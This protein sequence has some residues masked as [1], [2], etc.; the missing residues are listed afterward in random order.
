MRGTTEYENDDADSMLGDSGFD[1]ARILLQENLVREKELDHIICIIHRDSFIID[2]SRIN[3]SIVEATQGSMTYSW[4]GNIVVARFEGVELD[5]EDHGDMTMDDFRHA[6]DY[7][8]C[9]IDRDSGIGY[10]INRTL[11]SRTD[12]VKGQSVQVVYN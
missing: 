3:R 12:P 6:V 11:G 1:E 4:S 5:T 9:N 7:F 2:G 8:S 10:G